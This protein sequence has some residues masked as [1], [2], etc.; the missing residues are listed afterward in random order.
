MFSI[1]IKR[2]IKCVS[3]FTQLTG[4]IMSGVANHRKN[5]AFV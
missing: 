1:T 5:L 2:P 4:V 3:H